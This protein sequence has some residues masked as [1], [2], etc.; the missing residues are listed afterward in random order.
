[1]DA[2]LLFGFFIAIVLLPALGL[3][4][5]LYAIPLRIEATLALSEGRDDQGIGIAWGA[6]ALQIR[7]RG[8]GQLTQVLFLDRVVLSHTGPL[9]TRHEKGSPDLVPED[10]IGPD[11]K[12]R[13]GEL[14]HQ[15]QEITGPV[16]TFA[17]VLWQRSRFTGARGTVTFGLSNPALTGEVYGY[18]WASRF[19]L[20]ASRI[21]I[22]MIPV[23]DRPVLGYDIT[24]HGKIMHP[25][26]IHLAAINLIRDPGIRRMIAEERA[27]RPGAVGT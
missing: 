15:V 16:G 24:L 13:I 25:L 2:L 12:I 21:D 10:L 18:Y 7:G 20:L 22:E 17:S 27:G 6:V 3:A 8:A 1:M 19:I 9:E 4:L 23:F 11:G 5:L 14:I 26:L